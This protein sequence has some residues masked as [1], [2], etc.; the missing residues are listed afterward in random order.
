MT[1]SAWN[2]RLGGIVRPRAWAVLRLMTHSNVV[3]TRQDGGTFLHAFFR[4]LHDCRKIST[5]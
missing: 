3:A 1:S 4:S 5:Y 2:R